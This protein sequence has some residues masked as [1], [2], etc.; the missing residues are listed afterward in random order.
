MRKIVM[1][2]LVLV[3]LPLAALGE[4]VY[5]TQEDA[6]LLDGLDL[7]ISIQ[8]SRMAAL[9][10][11]AK[12]GNALALLTQQEVIES[13]QGYSDCDVKTDVR[14][15][16]PLAQS[17]LYLVCS[18]ETAEQANMKTLADMKAYLEA[19]EYGL[20]IMR[21]FQATNADY[22]AMLLMNEYTFDSEMFVDEAEELDSIGGGEY[23]FVASAAQAA[24]LEEEGY[25]VLGALTK[26]RTAAYPDLPCAGECDMPVVRGTYFALFAKKDGTA[27]APDGAAL[28][29]EVLAAN[30]MTA[31]DADLDL[32][33]DIEEYVEYM[34]A[35]GLFFY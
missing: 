19:N 11:V 29:D 33:Q 2:V 30:H 3:L 31:P 15:A 4:T 12:D 35:E 5:C 14:L 28:K 26:E 22:A 23:V 27:Q 32:D 1:L 13:L 24:E 16:Q 7:E 8:D 10:A 17:A 6:A 21:S 34:T 9:D 20:K 18:A 25:V